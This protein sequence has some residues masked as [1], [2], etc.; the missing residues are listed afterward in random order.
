MVVSKHPIVEFEKLAS[1]RTLAPPLFDNGSF[2]TP[3]QK[4]CQPIFTR[5]CKYV[6]EE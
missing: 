5:L 1:P 6:V 2:F 3:N 4:R